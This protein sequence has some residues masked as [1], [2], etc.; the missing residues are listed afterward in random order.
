MASKVTDASSF[1][2]LGLTD[3]SRLSLLDLALNR[4]CSTESSSS[5]VPSVLVC[6]DGNFSYALALAQHS[7]AA[8]RAVDITATCFLSGDELEATHPAAPDNITALLTIPRVAVHTGVD[9]T[10]VHE[11]FAHASFDRVVFNFP[12]HPERKKIQRHRELLAGFF[13]SAA[14]LLK[15]SVGDGGSGS[16]DSGGQVWVTLKGG[17]GGSGAELAG[18]HG[19]PYGTTWMSQEMA[20]GSGLVLACAAEANV[21]ELEAGGYRSVGFRGS[22]KSFFTPGSLVHVFCW[23][24]DLGRLAS[25]GL[26]SG[27]VLHPLVW[28]H[29]LCFWVDD[30]LTFSPSSLAAFLR[31]RLGPH[32]LAFA[33]EP[34]DEY[35][36]PSTGRQSRGFHVDIWAEQRAITKVT[37]K[38]SLVHFSRFRRLP[39]SLMRA[40]CAP[41]RP[42]SL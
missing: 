6:G 27:S 16:G 41:L 3:A 22:D 34:F 38:C 24:G 10:S 11:R 40:D 29:D 25:S 32:G 35:T 5:S 7:A 20:A 12:Q 14:C 42:S 26:G 33:A 23:P 28:R 17:Q 4:P 15:P 21:G 36:D 8:G 18:F 39:I 19:R 1:A 13:G 2:S 9:A 31:L 37:V 30:P